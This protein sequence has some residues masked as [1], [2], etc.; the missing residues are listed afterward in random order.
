M[1]E[2]VC[3]SA[4][5]RRPVL[6]NDAGETAIEGLPMVQP[7]HNG[8]ARVHLGRVAAL[9]VACTDDSEVCRICAK[10]SSR[11]PL[12][13]KFYQA[14]DYARGVYF[15]VTRSGS[16]EMSAPSVFNS[17]TIRINGQSVKQGHAGLQRVGLFTRSRLL[18]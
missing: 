14:G 9:H 11:N 10:V 15:I 4:W 1:A 17:S 12:R 8:A 16:M 6:D 2:L 5:N 7:F 18:A 13:R 3:P